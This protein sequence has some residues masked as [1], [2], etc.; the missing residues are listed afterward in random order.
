[1]QTGISCLKID[2][3]TRSSCRIF[4]SQVS[5]KPRKGLLMVS[6]FLKIDTPSLLSATL[7]AMMQNDFY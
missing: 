1:L 6:M 2:L 3:G 4:P 7:L 5:E